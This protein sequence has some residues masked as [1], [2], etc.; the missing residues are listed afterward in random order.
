MEPL[1]IQIKFMNFIKIV[2]SKMTNLFLN[3]KKTNF[4][5]NNNLLMITITPTQVKKN[6][7]PQIKAL[8]ILVLPFSKISLNI[9]KIFRDLV[10]DNQIQPLNQ[11]NIPIINQN[12]N[13]PQVIRNIQLMLMLDRNIPS[14][15]PI[16]VSGI[17][18]NIIIFYF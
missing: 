2:I 4:K 18:E 3:L 7:N 9:N 10:S 14:A 13:S 1:E 12:L 6:H 11:N 17:I 16:S 8:P 15:L 5:D